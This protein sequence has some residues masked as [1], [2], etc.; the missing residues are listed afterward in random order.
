[1]MQKRWFKVFI[2]FVSTSIFFMA[3]SIVISEFSPGPSEQQVMSYMS[4]M[5]NA[6]ENSLMGL[7]MTIEQDPELM[8]WIS[9]SMSMTIV[10]V[11]ASIVGGDYV[12]FNRRKNNG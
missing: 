5:M 12:R 8:K 10:L 3:S 9:N 2:W 1:M 6:M 7:S 4:G 11:I